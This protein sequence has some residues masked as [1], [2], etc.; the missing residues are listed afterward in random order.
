MKETLLLL[1][2]TAAFPQTIADAERERAVRYLESTRDQFLE[3]T[4]KLTDAQYRWKPAPERW[5]VAECAE[6]ITA[7]EQFI[8]A[9]FEKALEEPPKPEK[10]VAAAGRDELILKAVPNRTRRVQAPEEVQP[11]GRWPARE[12]Q[13]KAFEETRGRSLEFARSSRADLR[14]YF[15]PH[16]ILGDLDLY[17]WTLFL[18]A[19]CERHLAQMREV[20]ADPTF[21]KP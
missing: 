8:F 19:H 9:R 17:Q 13:K 18:G 3:L 11:A 1:M 14:S 15:Y 2:A 20:I 6:H 16:F 12:A 5:S 4:S 10:K 21:P 7:T